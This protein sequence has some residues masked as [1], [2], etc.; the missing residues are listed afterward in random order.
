MCGLTLLPRNTLPTILWVWMSMNEMSFESRFTIITTDVGSVSLTSAARSDNPSAVANSAAAVAAI[1][2]R[3]LSNIVRSPF[4]RLE[5]RL[6][7]DARQ[8]IPELRD[9]VLGIEHALQ[10]E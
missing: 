10:M 1:T 2:S 4:R 7:A 9:A 3:F 6:Q 5:T 8:E